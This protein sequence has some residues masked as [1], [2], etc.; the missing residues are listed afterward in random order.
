MK[1]ILLISLATAVI[2]TAAFL[3]F[4]RT[5]TVL[6]PL[7]AAVPNAQSATDPVTEQKRRIKVL[8][9]QLQETHSESV[10]KDRKIEQLS[11]ATNSGF[12]AL[13][14]QPGMKDFIKEQQKGMVH[15]MIQDEF[16]DLNAY[17]E[18]PP[19]KEDKVNQLLQARKEREVEFG[20]DLM[21]STMEERPALMARLEEDLQVMDQQLKEALGP[22]GE[23]IFEWY[24]QTQPERQT[25]REFDQLLAAGGRGLSEAAANQLFTIM[26]EERQRAAFPVNFH[27]PRGVQPEQYTP[28]LLQQFFE[29][30]AAI[31]QK[32][33]LRAQGILPPDQW[34]LLTEAQKKQLEK[35]RA[36]LTMI[37]T[38]IGRP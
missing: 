33:A 21:G 16:G 12:A 1:T 4:E 23:K 24:Q 18:F 32:I 5:R 27:N 30:N 14:K 2:G 34:K 22:E 31:D 8:R 28:D 36:N 9:A 35:Q 7:P 38:L 29:R 25:I 19:E 37:Q 17:L 20:M 6:A 3:I 26:L 15:K 13:F 11:S 10:E